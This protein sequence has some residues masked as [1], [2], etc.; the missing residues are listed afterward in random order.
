MNDYV[1]K[2]INDKKNHN[3]HGD[4]SKFLLKYLLKT[5]G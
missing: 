5:F 3:D 1:E 2:I 4:M